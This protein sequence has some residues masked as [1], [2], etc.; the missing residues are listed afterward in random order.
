METV[1]LLGGGNNRWKKSFPYMVWMLHKE[2]EEE[3][4]L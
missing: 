3:C 1:Q 4:T 2:E